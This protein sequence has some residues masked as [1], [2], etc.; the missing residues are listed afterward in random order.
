MSGQ[1]TP[2]PDKWA[3]IHLKDGRALDASEVWTGGVLIW[4]GGVLVRRA[5]SDD[6]GKEVRDVVVALYDMITV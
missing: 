5:L 6:L 3:W 1:L 2:D 4:V